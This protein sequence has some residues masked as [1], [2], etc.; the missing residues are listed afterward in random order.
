MSQIHSPS[1]HDLNQFAIQEATN[2]GRAQASTH[3]AIR[4]VL[5]RFPVGERVS[6][7]E[8]YPPDV[9]LE[10]INVLE[11]FALDIVCPTYD[12]ERNRQGYKPKKQACLY[13]SLWTIPVDAKDSLYC[14]KT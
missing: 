14:L 3:A 1:S 7:P 4:E 12:Q 11:R 9:V 13:G 10:F 5:D 8:D 6:C 2:A